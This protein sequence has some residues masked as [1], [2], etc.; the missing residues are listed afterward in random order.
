[1][2]NGIGAVPAG[3]LGE[4]RPVAIYYEEAD[5]VEY[6]RNDVPSLHQRIDGFLTLVLD[7]KTRDP[8]GF[9]LKGFKNYYLRHIRPKTDLS[10]RE[11][12]LLANVLEIAVN[13]IGEAVFNHDAYRTA[14]EIA[15]HDEVRLDEVPVAA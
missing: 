12:V 15:E 1:M 5:I 14:R 7:L 9:T 10:E 4:Y 13:E 2:T 8:I 11:F 6:V 3:L